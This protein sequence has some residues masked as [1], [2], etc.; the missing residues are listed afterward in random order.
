MFSNEKKIHGTL[1][2]S[3]TVVMT[4]ASDVKMSSCVLRYNI[5]SRLKVRIFRR[6]MGKWFSKVLLFTSKPLINLSAF[7]FL[8]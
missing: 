6:E 8:P 5:V 7:V 4:C 2:D 3:F 1:P